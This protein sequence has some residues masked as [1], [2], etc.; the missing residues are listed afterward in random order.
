[1][2]GAGAVVGMV[3]G[4]RRDGGRVLVRALPQA[5]RPVAVKAR[6]L[7]IAIARSARLRF[8]TVLLPLVTVRRR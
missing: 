2:E 1:M 4:S 7:A 3:G 8:T 6:R 5:A